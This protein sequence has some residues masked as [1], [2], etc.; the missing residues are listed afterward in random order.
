M[1]SLYLHINII[2]CN[3][4]IWRVLVFILYTWHQI[5]FPELKYSSQCDFQNK[6]FFVNVCK[7][8]SRETEPIMFILHIKNHIYC[9]HIYLCVYIYIYIYIYIWR[10]I[11]YKKFAYVSMRVGKI[12]SLW[13]RRHR[14]S[15]CSSSKAISQEESI[16]LMKSKANQLEN[17][18]KLKG[19]LVFL[20]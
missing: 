20:F 4:V 16:L 17:S 1:P 18:L 14:E 5:R 2:K 13:C 7:G 3:N 6:M 11:Y 15:W 12:C 8:F 19:E 10:E 9:V